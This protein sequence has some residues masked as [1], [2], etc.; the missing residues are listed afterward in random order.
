MGGAGETHI[1]SSACPG[2]LPC[3]AGV[4][5]HGQSPTSAPQSE[6]VEQ[7]EAVQA[8]RLTCEDD[9]ECLVVG[10][11]LL[12]CATHEHRF[13]C[14]SVHRGDGRA[15]SEETRAVANRPRGGMQ[16][17]K[18]RAREY[19]C[20]SR[21]VVPLGTRTRPCSRPSLLDCA[22]REFLSSSV[23]LALRSSREMTAP[24]HPATH[25][26]LS[27]AHHGQRPPTPPSSTSDSGSLSPPRDRR[28]RD[29]RDS[30]TTHDRSHA[31]MGDFDPLEGYTHEGQGREQ[32][33][34]GD[35]LRRR[36]SQAGA[37]GGGEDLYTDEGAGSGQQS[38][39]G[40]RNR[41]SMRTGRGVAL[42]PPRDPDLFLSDDDFQV[43]P[44]SSRSFPSCVHA[45]ANYTSRRSVSRW[46]RRRDGTT[47][48]SSSSRFLRSARSCT[49]GQRTGPTPLS[50]RLSSSTC[51]S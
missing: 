20:S 15:T 41:Q 13:E 9:V 28:N 19:L 22:R 36:R 32:G 6:V 3:P 51:T 39:R 23:S 26:K 21:A 49:A 29:A 12:V 34:R 8:S 31:G 35:G 44:P 10:R 46:R 27:H 2:V 45:D 14:V 43:A 5:A 1:A 25:D 7:G 37:G 18:R 11:V 16:R 42:E 40:R 4:R 17:E 47:S 24:P 38:R 48:R 30:P 33:P 50:S